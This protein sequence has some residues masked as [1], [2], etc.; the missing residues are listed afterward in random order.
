MIVGALS[1]ALALL[2]AGDGSRAAVRRAY[3][4]SDSAWS[5]HW[6][7]ARGH[8]VV[9]R[10][11]FVLSSV[12]ILQK[13]LV[14]LEPGVT[15]LLDP[16]D[17]EART[18]LLAGSYQDHVW[19]AMARY[20]GD[21]AVVIDVGSHYGLFALK[22]AVKVGKAGRVLAVEP[23]PE[24][25]TL[26]RVNVAASAAD[27]VTILPVACTDRE[28]TLV[29]YA[30]PL[31]NTARSSLARQNAE[32]TLSTAPREYKVRGRAIDD[33]VGEMKIARVDVIKIDVEGAELQVLQ[34]AVGVLKRLRPTIV[35][36]IGPEKEVYFNTKP[37]DVLSLLSSAG[38][39]EG[40]LLGGQDWEFTPRPNR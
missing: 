30:S 38:Y 8:F 12:G 22:A 10:F 6:P 11:G 32:V 19:N 39:E 21:G 35:V 33:I 16:R 2:L 23:N 27:N 18:L 4:W 15:M 17:Y 28:R 3:V 5:E 29:F 36:E 13:D 26:L 7:F 40:R 37:A 1:I 24:T 14:Q 34:G 31:A 20:I 25:L 9:N